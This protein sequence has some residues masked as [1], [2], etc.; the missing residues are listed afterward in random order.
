MQPFISIVLPAY[1]QAHF[2]PQ[3]L[4]SIFA[5]TCRD[6]EL[7]VVNDGS[8]DDTAN[9]LADYQRRHA[10]AVIEQANQGLPGALNTGFRQARGEYLT[11]TSSDNIM[12]PNM[13]E[14]L[15]K[16]LDDNP[17]VGLVYADRYLITDDG[18]NLGRFDLPE[19]DPHLL[20]HV[21]MVH[22]CFLY[23][24]A[25]MAQVGLYDPEFI[26][27]EDWEYWIRISRH[28]RMK[29]IPQALYHYRLHGTSMTSELMR[30]TARNIGYREF[31]RRIRRRAPL[32]WYV[33]K[34]KWWWLRLTNPRHPA[35]AGRASWLQ[36]AA[37]AANPTHLS[38]MWYA[39]AT[40]GAGLF[41]I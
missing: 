37:R 28:F 14:V 18:E 9:V 5:Q 31:S 24:R 3:S 15:S 30:G 32:A 6:F 12:L 13:L 25:C 41:V 2:L 1:N 4:D 16:A 8:T 11:W 34:F 29:H 20:L 26:Y 21:N 27:G 19:Y 10:F 40:G 17:A 22:C 7:I 39:V 36:A 35:F 38:A 33:G 23:R